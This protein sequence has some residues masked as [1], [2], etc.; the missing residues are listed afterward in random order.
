MPK[1]INNKFVLSYKGEINY[2]NI[3]VM[4]GTLKT[5][6]EEGGFKLGTYKKVLAVMVECLENIYKYL[7]GVHMDPFLIQKNEPYFNLE[8]INDYFILKAGNPLFNKD[9]ERL[10]TKLKMINDLDEERLKN[11]YKKIITDGKFT[12]KGGAGLGFI[13]MVKTTKNKIDFTFENV[14]PEMS[15]FHITLK[16]PVN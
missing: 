6:M 1:A 14:N 16:I 7:D 9:I 13:E 12:D 2:D 15:Y 11:L 4:L 3:G 8:F 5:K 10:E